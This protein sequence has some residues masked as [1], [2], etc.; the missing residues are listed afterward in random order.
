MPGEGCAA[1]AAGPLAAEEG[2]P[3]AD[4]VAVEA[5]AAAAAVSEAAV[6]A[7]VAAVVS[8]VD[9][10][11]AAVFEVFTGTVMAIPG[12]M[13]GFGIRI[14]GI[15]AIGATTDIRILTTAPATDMSI[16]LRR[17]PSPALTS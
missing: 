16:L 1:V 15:R 2:F 3:V 5:F 8:V 17:I 12:F 6:E 4:S 11:D 7:F 10:A 14:C 9:F 13:G